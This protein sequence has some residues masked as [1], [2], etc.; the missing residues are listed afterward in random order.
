MNL[1]KLI[2]GIA[3]IGAVISYPLIGTVVLKGIGI[4]FTLIVILGAIAVIGG[5]KFILDGINEK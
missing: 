3:L 4:P 5:I 1:L 2:L